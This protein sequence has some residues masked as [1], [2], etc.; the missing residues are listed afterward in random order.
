MKLHLYFQSA[1]SYYSHYLHTELCESEHPLCDG[2]CVFSCHIWHVVSVYITGCQLPLSQHAQCFSF[3][4]HLQSSSALPYPSLYILLSQ[5]PDLP[6]LPPLS[7]ITT[8]CFRVPLKTLLFPPP[9]PLRS[10]LHPLFF[11]NADLIAAIL[12]HCL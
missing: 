4:L 7:Y 10:F 9:L 12:F 2:R 6:S 1:R 8:S 5:I 11:L 3:Y